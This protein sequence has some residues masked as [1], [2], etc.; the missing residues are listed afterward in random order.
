MIEI[1]QRQLF[2]IVCVLEGGYGL[3]GG[4]FK[5]QPHP[6]L[7]ALAETLVPESLKSPL[8]LK[9]KVQS[10]HLNCLQIESCYNKTLWTDK[11]GTQ[12]GALGVSYGCDWG[13]NN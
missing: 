10:I 5:L 2:A 4:N 11:L 13:Q 6:E 3:S 9:T 1:L 8:K 7:M 12:E